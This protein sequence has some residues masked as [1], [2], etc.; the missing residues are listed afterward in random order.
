MKRAATTVATGTIPAYASPCSGAVKYSSACSCINI[1]P[2][3]ITAATPLA[4]TTISDA[5]TTQ[6]STSTTAT[7]Q[8]TA[9][10]SVTNFRVV[11]EGDA[12]FSGQYLI[13]QPAGTN[14][15]GAYYTFGFG[16]P[17]EVFTLDGTTLK[18]VT[19]SGLQAA[20]L[21][22]DNDYNFYIGTPASITEANGLTF[23]CSV[24]SALYL[25]CSGAPSSPSFNTFGR[26]GGTLNLFRADGSPT[27]SQSFQNT[28]QLKIVPVVDI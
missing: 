21:L 17:G 7:V 20:G 18:S 14:G 22:R 16:T 24:D 26:C 4:S 28:F 5:T 8:A 6:T 13:P 9:T 25:H 19:H 3:T 2:T 15:G 10:L 1:F 27:C 11:V 12:E 23:T